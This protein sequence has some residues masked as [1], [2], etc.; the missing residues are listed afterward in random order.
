MAI[1]KPILCLDFDGVVHSYT[2]G[3][4]GVDK[5]PDP[6]VEGVFE[7][8]LMASTLFEIKIFSSRSA[9]REGRVAM[10]NW[11]IHYGTLWDE[12][13]QIVEG[14]YPKVDFPEH[15]PAAFISIDDRVVL[16]KGEWPNVFDLRKFK[17][18]HQG[19]V[20]EKW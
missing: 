17:P 7:F 6:P 5:I 10:E 9:Q 3:W 8:I 4:K 15:K 11:F 19:K 12:K 14:E 20:V 2:S 16:F 1:R 13:N 18:W